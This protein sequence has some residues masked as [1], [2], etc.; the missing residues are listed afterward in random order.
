MAA[1]KTTDVVSP[2]V[3]GP[4]EPGKGIVLT[5]EQKRR[6]RAR[7]IAVA[8]VLFGLIVLFYLITIFK[9]GGNIA[10]RSI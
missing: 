10:A 1:K 2:T 6:L 4:A 7:N 3:A 5:A 9:L 8:A